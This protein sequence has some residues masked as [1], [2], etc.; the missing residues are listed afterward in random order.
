MLSEYFEKAK[1]IKLALVL[2]DIRREPTP[3]D[4]VMFDYLDYHGIS[5]VVVATKADKIAK[6]KRKNACVRIEKA[7]GNRGIEEVIASSS[8]D[9]TGKE[10]LLFMIGKHLGEE[11]A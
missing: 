4:L 9:R 11:P 7:L 1:N 2:M 8:F 3:E 10:A 6:S 5:Y